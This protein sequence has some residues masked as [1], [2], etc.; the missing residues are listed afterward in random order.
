[1]C[2]LPKVLRITYLVAAVVLLVSFT[3]GAHAQEP[4]VQVS[5]E[6]KHRLKMDTDKYRVYDVLVTPGDTMLFHEHKADN[7]AVL[8][9]QSELTNEFQGG[10][11]TDIQA[12]PGMVS[13]AQASRAK[14]YVH[15]VL[16]RGGAPFRN[17]TIEFLQPQAPAD[18][19]GGPEQVDPALTTLREFPRGRAF[20]L[21]LEPNQATKLP[22]RVSDVFVVCLS[23]GSVVQQVLGQ[24]K[25]SWD[26]K[27]GDFRLL[28]QPREVVLKNQ[29]AARVDLAIIALQ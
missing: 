25:T 14:P 21:N 13:F 15:R 29:G 5:A 10:Q 28:E 20:R 24:S 4:F 2:T 3:S 7:F 12:Q 1:M 18:A 27:I 8:L 16:L 17:I 22:S 11:K 19:A 26:C 9:S 23:D 6:P